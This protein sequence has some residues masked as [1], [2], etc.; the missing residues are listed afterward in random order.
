MFDSV[1]TD[2]V[3][4]VCGGGHVIR[5]W[6]TKSLKCNMSAYYLLE[7]HLYR[8]E[9]SEAFAV[10]DPVHPTKRADGTWVLAFSYALVKVFFGTVSRHVEIHG[11]CDECLPVL[12]PCLPAAWKQDLLHEHQPWVEYQLVFTGDGALQAIEPVK[13]QTRSDVRREIINNDGVIPLEDGSVLAQ[14]H[15][16]RLSIKHQ[17]GRRG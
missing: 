14:A 2:D 16:M 13:V 12:Q 10:V 3:R 1:H 6:Q 4:L 8:Q 17:K 7:G 15:F 11:F 5:D 9:N